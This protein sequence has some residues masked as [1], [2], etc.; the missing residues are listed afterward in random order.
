MQT[1]DRASNCAGKSESQVLLEV[2]EVIDKL[3]SDDPSFRAATTVLFR[4]EPFETSAHTAVAKA[5]QGAAKSLFGYELEHSAHSAWTDAALLS[6]AGL[7]TILVGPSG[8]GA[9]ET[10]EWVDLPSVANLSKLLA[11]T[12]LN[13]CGQ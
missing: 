3:T 1:A 2:Q 10:K 8:S 11:Q 12:V 4:R 7:D 9:H 13:Y 6:A 5:L